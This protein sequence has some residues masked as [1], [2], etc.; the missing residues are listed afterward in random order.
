MRWVLAHPAVRTL[1]LTIL[2]FNV[3]FGAAWS[4]L[5]LYSLDRLHMGRSASACSP[6]RWPSAACCGMLGYGWLERHVSLG[7]IMRG[8]LVIETLTHLVLA[9][10]TLPLG[11]DGGDGG[12][13]RPRVRL[14][15][16]VARRCDSAPYRCRCRAGS[17]A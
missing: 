17:T 5:V 7:V 13:R 14:G 15:Y 16:D 1:V 12:L 6:R 10:N 8:G 3:T 11:G 9:V 4:V 2:V